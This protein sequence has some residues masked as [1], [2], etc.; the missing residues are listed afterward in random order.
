MRLL[1]LLLKDELVILPE[2]AEIAFT[3]RLAP[4]SPANRPEIEFEIHDNGPGL[5]A[6]ALRLLFD[7]FVPRSDSPQEYG[8]SLMACYFI[9]HHHGGKIEARRAEPHGTIFRLTL[10]LDPNRFAPV[11]TNNE[12]LQQMLA[13]DSLWEKWVSQE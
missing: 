2:G 7:P 9:V 12:R 8:I 13:N 6:E 1:E 3:A 10:P 5:P 4:G 11:E